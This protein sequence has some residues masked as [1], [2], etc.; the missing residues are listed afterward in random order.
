MNL[1]THR[2]GRTGRAGRTGISVIISNLKEKHKL[3]QIEKQINKKIT[4]LQVPNGKEICK[5]QLFH[6][7]DKMENVEVNHR[8]IDSFLPEIYKKLERFER[9]ELIKKF[10]S[11]EFNR[12]LEYYK[13]SSDLSHPENDHRNGDK[14]SAVSG[15]TRFFIN[16][17]KTDNLKPAVLIGMINDYT[18]IRD[19]EIGEIE[20]LNNFSFFE[21]DSNYAEVVLKS[22]SNKKFRNRQVAVEIASQKRGKGNQ[23][24]RK[25]KSKPAQNK[26]FRK[27]GTK[28][29]KSKANK[30]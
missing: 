7:I 1:Y 23:E 14:H 24:K 13:N 20:I 5:K 8:E 29:K 19:I 11:V 26:R 2:S 12:F 27:A 25:R 17:G 28:K 4:N 22:F 6:L 10:V 16:L 18:N 21:T 15:F 3:R 30:Y 9:E